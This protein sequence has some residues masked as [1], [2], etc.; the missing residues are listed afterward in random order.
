MSVCI[1]GVDLSDTYSLV[2]LEPVALE[3]KGMESVTKSFEIGISYFIKLMESLSKLTSS[4]TYRESDV[5]NK[6]V[7][8]Y[9]ER[10]Y[11][12]MQ[13]TLDK[14][15]TVN[16]EINERIE[17][18]MFEIS[19]KEQ[20]QRQNEIKS[21]KLDQQIRNLQSELEDLQKEKIKAKEK[22]KAIKRDLQEAEKKLREARNKQNV[23]EGVRTA[24]SVIP[25]FGSIVRVVTYPIAKV[26]KDNVDAA[27]NRVDTEYRYKCA[28]ERQVDSKESE[29]RTNKDSS[30]TL[31]HN[32]EQLNNDIRRMKKLRKSLKRNLDLQ[33]EACVK[34]KKC[35]HFVGGAHCRAEVLH[36][37]IKYFYD[38]S[39]VI[40]PLRDMARHLSSKQ[41]SALG[42]LPSNLQVGKAAGKLQMIAAAAECQA[43]LNTP[44]YLKGKRTYTI[45]CLMLKHCN[46]V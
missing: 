11:N 10:L 23:V 26:L 38:L 19:R 8:L 16:S 17:E 28:K 18:V 20:E 24:C 13:N 1:A 14:I 45:I 37:Q 2:Q 9:S 25:I 46:Q 43:A 31:Q 6:D 44:S 40:E 4:V 36:D 29:I 32:K 22:Y 42:M 39:A 15:K 3:R 5:I 21:A 35:L 33:A 41:A 34:M 30:Q 27:R 12:H 7:W